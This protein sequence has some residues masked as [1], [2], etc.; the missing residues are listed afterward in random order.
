M[1]DYSENTLVRDTAGAFLHDT[2]GWDVQ[3]AFDQETFGSGRRS[4]F[5]RSS[6]HEVL[7]TRYFRRALQKLNPWLN[8]NQLHIAE[9]LFRERP[10]QESLLACNERKYQLIRDGIPV[11]VR[12]ADGTMETHRAKVID[13]D[14]PEA[15][16]FLAVKE[17]TV[18]G[19]LYTR[20]A[21]LVGFVNGI[22]LLFAEFK[23]PNVALRTG[24]EQ[25][26]RD[27]QQTIPHLFR[28]NAFV[29][30]SN[31]RES[32]IGTLGSKYEFFNEWKHL[33]EGD[34]SSVSLETMLRGVCTKA[35]FL[36]LVE[37]FIMFDHAHHRT[38]KILARCHQYLGVNEAIEAYRSRN[39][40]HGKLGVFWHTQGSGK[41][42]SMVFL[43]RKIQRKFAEAPTFV[44]LTD[45]DELNRQLS[46]T[47]A[48]CGVFGTVPAK[49]FIAQSGADLIRRLQSHP[50]F[51]FTLI[52]KFN[53]P[54]AEPL[55]PDHGVLVISDEAHRSQYGTFA[56][57]MCRLLPEAARIGF[58]GTPLL[59]GDQLTVRTFGS[60]VSIYD[61]Q[62]A[63]EDGA[64]V[65]LYYENRGDLLRIENP[66]INEE[67][68]DAIEAADLDEQ[69]EER[70]AK[71]F[72]REIHVLM[73]RP[74]LDAIA[75]DFVEHYTSLW[76]SGKAMFVCL[77][78][79]T[80][81]MMYDLVQQYW[82]EKMQAVARA[83]DAARDQ[84]Q[85]MELQRQLDWMQETEMAV[86]ISGTQNEQQTFAKWGLDIT[87][88]R[89]KMVHR[90]LDRDYKDPEHPFRIVFVC[91]M[92]LTG[93]DVQTLA[94]LYLDKPL[95]AHT[96]MQTIA[97]ANRVAEGKANGL[98]I[99]Y[100]GVLKALKKALASYTTRGGQGPS[101]VTPKDELLAHVTELITAG[102]QFL[103]AHGFPLARLVEAQGMAKLA[104]LQDAVE[105]VCTPLLVRQ[106]FARLGKELRRLARC[107]TPGDLSPALQA[108]KDALLA[109]AENLVTKQAPADTTDLLVKI[110]GI[111]NEHVTV[112]RV[113]EGR[114]A[115]RK[116]DISSID[117]DLL[118]KEFASRE[119]PRLKFKEISD[120]V[121]G[122][123]DRMIH[124]NPTRIDYYRRYEEIIAAYN[125]AQDK[126]EI[127]RIFIDLMN[128]TRDMS[129]EQKR[130]TREGFTSDEQLTIYDLL[131]KDNLS[132]QDIQK[133]KALSVELLT[134]IEDKIRSYSH[135]TE[136][137][138]TR[139]DVEMM[140]RDKLWEELPDPS[141]QQ[142]EIDRCSE[143]VFRYALEHFQDV[144]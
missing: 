32:R 134:A 17:L 59:T 86:V 5:G 138:T 113:A 79:I 30:F 9:N 23:K 55:H 96:L 31:G 10:G 87:P 102:K 104:R 64:T 110:H 62:Q 28:Y 99:D 25:N 34:E 38:A 29:L 16:D 35:N 18:Q 116:F 117:F 118:R 78:R 125:E 123:L 139:A 127:E 103:A 49:S 74:R 4:T 83:R 11:P 68:L 120:L 142:D 112:D 63:V 131:V 36:D 15:N 135:W 65:P 93:F 51:I 13:F 90:E 69:Q 111:M 6:A 26:Y 20:R 122:E 7:L 33:A 41:S 133:V 80:C 82:A 85:A 94:C 126:A 58:T 19:E 129:E 92:W 50:S 53:Q 57:N 3:M 27:Y 136:K 106:N 8:D 72:Q 98:I 40:L 76:Q 44:L 48:G 119:H 2:L 130:Y 67:I 1:N 73:A 108:E 141:Y 132:R 128:L 60:Y 107:L 84:Q 39:A 124:A 43:V 37:N 24:Y 137:D 89:K 91:A 105:A 21:D 42:Y 114:E 109:I 66:A 100:V 47:F 52:Q 81:V 115:V 12:R 88:H 45:R 56:E 22:P 121:H 143:K 75:R 140:I 97:R 61:F 101:P 54:L 144:A 46:E 14:H 77:N 71:D 95:K 70:L